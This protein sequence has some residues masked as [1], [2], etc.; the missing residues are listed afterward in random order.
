MNG[1]GVRFVLWVQGCSIGCKG[2]FNPDT[3][4]HELKTL[5]T[6]PDMA[7]KILNSEGIDGVTF[8]GGEPFEQAE[9]LACLGKMLKEKAL[10]VIVFTGFTL[11]K[12]K[13][14]KKPEWDALLSVTDLLIDGRYMDSQKADLRWR[15]SSN[16]RLHFLT[17]RIVAPAREYP[18]NQRQLEVHIHPDG[19]IIMTGFPDMPLRV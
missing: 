19:Q 1:P 14:G 16:Q 9:A 6:V 10:S 12:L 15:G 2:C 3:W 4:S 17:D 7:D 13:T 11:E 5:I 8:S 18:E